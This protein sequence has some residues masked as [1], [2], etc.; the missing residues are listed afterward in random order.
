MRTAL[1][2]SQLATKGSA[3]DD[4]CGPSA[5]ET[6]YANFRIPIAA[7]CFLC[8]SLDPQIRLV[9]DRRDTWRRVGLAILEPH[10]STVPWIDSIGCRNRRGDL[11]KD[12][13]DSRNESPLDYDSDVRFVP[14]SVRLDLEGTRT[15]N[16]SVE[17]L[18]EHPFQP[19]LP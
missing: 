14:S 18:Q 1:A 9:P 15:N 6:F 8:P 3:K 2:R 17:R 4:C 7:A 11:G 16:T 5:W 10:L 12:R 19:I 13:R